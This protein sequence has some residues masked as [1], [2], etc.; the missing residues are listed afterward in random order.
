MQPA[1]HKRGAGCVGF[2]LLWIFFI[3]RGFAVIVM[4]GIWKWV[5]LFVKFKAFTRLIGPRGNKSGAVV[6]RAGGIIWI[7]GNSSGVGQ[8]VFVLPRTKSKLFKG[9]DVALKQAALQFGG[10]WIEKLTTWGIFVYKVAKR[11]VFLWHIVTPLALRAFLLSWLCCVLLL[12]AAAG[13]LSVEF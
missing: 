4:R 6:C 9:F 13:R 2:I 5:K 1:T 10:K 3:P 7:K 8:V 11:R 12:F